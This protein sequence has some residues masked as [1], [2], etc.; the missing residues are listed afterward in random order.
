VI[1]RGLTTTKHDRRFCVCCICHLASGFGVS[2]I[3][4]CGRSHCK[5]QYLKRL[6]IASTHI[7]CWRPMKLF[8][9]Q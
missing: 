2:S 9:Y 7:G 5:I 4:V 8:C 6:I 3:G 1:L